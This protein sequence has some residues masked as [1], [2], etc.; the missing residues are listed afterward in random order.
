MFVTRFSYTPETWARLREDPEDRSA[1]A[2]ESIEAAGG[3]LHGFWYALGEFDGIT[4]W[5]APSRVAL[6]SALVAIAG[7]SVTSKLET[8]VLLSVEEAMD[9]MKQSARVHHRAPGV[10]VRTPAAVA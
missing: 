5:E 3:K 9:A 2:R 7:S 8:T 1:A 6:A 4:L 10:T